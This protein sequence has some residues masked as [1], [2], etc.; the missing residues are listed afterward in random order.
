[1]PFYAHPSISMAWP[2]IRLNNL[3]L[4]QLV[5][6][7]LLINKLQQ[8][9]GKKR[10]KI[11]VHP[12]RKLLLDATD[13]L[14]EKHHP[15]M[16]TGQMILRPSGVS[17]GSLYHH[18]EDASDV[19]ETVMLDRFF[20]RAMKDIHNIKSVVFNA[21]DRPSYIEAV[22]AITVEVQSTKNSAKRIERVNLLAYAASRPRMLT[23]LAEKQQAVSVDFA[24]TMVYAQQRGW[25]NQNL[26]P[27]SLSVF[28]QAL[29]LGRVLD[30]ISSKHTAPDD[31]NQIV[32]MCIDKILAAEPV[33]TV[34]P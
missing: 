22:S 10:G 8:Y 21:K 25:I 20:D 11:T 14:F 33:T 3:V 29:T 15:D 27:L 24:D 16:I 1:M 32:I 12:T 5:G 17:H 7:A 13:A 4:C 26:S 19:V 2:F 18:F 23:K 30:D 28:F 9:D 31:W 34:R 6:S